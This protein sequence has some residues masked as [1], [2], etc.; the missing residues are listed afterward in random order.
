MDQ[1]NRDMS[2]LEVDALERLELLKEKRFERSN[3]RSRSIA[4]KVSWAEASWK[5]T[6][7][8]RLDVALQTL[9]A[10]CQVFGFNAEGFDLPL[11]ASDLILEA[12]RRGL[13]GIRL[14]REGNRIRSLSFGGVDMVDLKHML[15]KGYSLEALGRLCGLREDAKCLFPFGKLD[16]AAF[17]GEARLPADASEWFNALNETK[18]PSQEEVNEALR[19]F[20]D[21][22]CPSVGWYLSHYL[23]KD[24]FLTVK[25]A[26]ILLR[27]FFDLM[28]VH[29]VQSRK[30]TISSYSALGMQA[31]LMRDRRPGFRSCGD[32]RVFG[33]R[34][35]VSL[36][37]W[38]GLVFTRLSFSSSRAG[39]AGV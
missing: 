16:S 7:W 35:S 27:T 22:R 21:L 9:I 15:S 2:R 12:K 29:A 28:G 26:S 30:M 32:F 34:P 39:F 13:K 17:L 36:S 8:G 4:R 23:E 19:L 10:S 1:L 20:E 24:V 18:S 38:G 37:L 25:S 11:L 5:K 33:V 31:R 3:L 6:L 14:Q